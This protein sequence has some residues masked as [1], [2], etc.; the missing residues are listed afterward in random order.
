MQLEEALLGCCGDDGF[1]GFIIEYDGEVPPEN[2][3]VGI[4]GMLEV[5][6][7]P[8]GR[9]YPVIVVEELTIKEIRGLEFVT[10]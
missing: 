10:R 4:V 7:P 6:T 8:Q 3:W 9:P 2:E 1:A 5:R